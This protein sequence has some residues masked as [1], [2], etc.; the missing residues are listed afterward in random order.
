MGQLLSRETQDFNA[1]SC[2]VMPCHALWGFTQMYDG[3]A[4]ALSQCFYVAVVI[5]S[6]TSVIQALTFSNTH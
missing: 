6:G 2:L 5:S 1:F 4:A 3:A